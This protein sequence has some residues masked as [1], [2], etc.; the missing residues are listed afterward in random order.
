MRAQVWRDGIS[1]ALP[2]HA[3]PCSLAGPPR[4]QI[5]PQT[6]S[7]AKL[8]APLLSHQSALPKLL[9]ITLS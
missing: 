8:G 9:E 5:G 7:A 3:T 2:D 1:Q 4:K 6:S